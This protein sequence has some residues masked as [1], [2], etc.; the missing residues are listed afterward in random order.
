VVA[1]IGWLRGIDA[2][3]SEMHL[4]LSLSEMVHTTLITNLMIQWSINAFR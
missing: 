1:V 2:S 3:L 4:M